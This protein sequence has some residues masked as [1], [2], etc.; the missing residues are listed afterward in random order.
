MAT[1]SPVYLFKHAKHCTPNIQSDCHQWFSDSFRVHQ[2]RFRPKLRPGPDWGAYREGKGR[3]EKGRDRSTQ[4]FSIRPVLNCTILQLHIL[5]YGFMDSWVCRAT[6]PSNGNQC[7]NCIW[8]PALR[9]RFHSRFRSRSV[10][11]SVKTLPVP[12]V[13]YAVAG[14]CSLTVAR[15]AQEAGR[16]VSRAKE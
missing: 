8:F 4:I 9:C 10:T 6:R 2:I 15:Q 13:P 12:A 1:P 7:W 5:L 16:R 14:A 3:G 11:V